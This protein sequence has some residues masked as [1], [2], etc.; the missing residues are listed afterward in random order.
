MSSHIRTVTMP[1]WG[2]EMTEGLVGDWY[3]A[4]G[5]QISEGDDLV[6][7]ETS[8]IVN[9]VTSPTSGVLRR[10]IA[11][12]GDNLPVGAVLGVLAPTDID[13]AEIEAFVKHLCIALV[14]N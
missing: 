7:V 5:A 11:S 4:V 8:K 2:M 6:D 9:T 14:H 13:D 1:K 12:P 10:I 3:V